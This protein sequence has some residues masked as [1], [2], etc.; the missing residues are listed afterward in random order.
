MPL[1]PL[2]PYYPPRPTTI[3]LVQLDK[4][5]RK[6]KK[7]KKERADA[8][9]ITGLQDGTPSKKSRKKKGSSLEPAEMKPLHNPL[10]KPALG[11]I[12]KKPLGALGAPLGIKSETLASAKE[13][14]LGS[15]RR[16]D[17]D[18]ASGGGLTSLSRERRDTPLDEMLSP[19]PWQK[20][21]FPI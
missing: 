15:M 12:G 10:D 2:E 1:L 20:L 3:I 4:K 18:K 7:K 9:M 14:R 16:D 19:D 11:A 21:G 8:A 5:D 17:D 13:P 6:D